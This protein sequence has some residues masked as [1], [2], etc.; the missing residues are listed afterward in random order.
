VAARPTA[1]PERLFDQPLSG[2]DEDRRPLPERLFG[3]SV[4]V[5][6]GE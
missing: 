3:R 2:F 1:A 5:L 6:E 4:D